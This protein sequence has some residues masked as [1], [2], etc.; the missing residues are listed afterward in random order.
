MILHYGDLTDSTNLV[1]I[2][3]QVCFSSEVCN[4]NKT[5]VLSVLW[6]LWYILS[7]SQVKPDEI[8]NLGAQSHVK[9]SL[10]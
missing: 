4:F 10:W 1:K 9:V 5:V 8:Y 6:E 2:V 7:F 3:S